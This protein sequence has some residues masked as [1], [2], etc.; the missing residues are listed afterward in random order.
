MLIQLIE[1]YVLRRNRKRDFAE[2]ILI[3]ISAIFI[4]RGIWGLTDIY[5]FPI[6]PAY[7][8]WLSLVVGVVL[9]MLAKRMDQ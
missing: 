2:A 9:M 6:H 4:W 8:F 7:S 3:D 1:K 5:F